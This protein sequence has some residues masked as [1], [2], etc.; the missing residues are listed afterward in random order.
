MAS[1][2]IF[3]G[4]N[5]AIPG[6]ERIAGE[7]FQEFNQYLG[8]LKENGTIQ[9]FDAVILNAHGGDLNGFFLVRG[10]P[11]KLDALTETADW[12]AHITRGILH[13]EGFGVVRG[14]TG[15]QVMER[16]RLW[17]SLIPK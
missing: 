1:N 11:A 4:W 14:S 9:L 17:M 5:R 2:V 13:E 6:R 15:D 10:E 12:M 3:V 7:H 8:K 16:M